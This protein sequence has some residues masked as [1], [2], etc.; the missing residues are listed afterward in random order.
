[1]SD[2]GQVIIMGL[3]YLIKDAL[4]LDYERK[5]ESDIQIKVVGI[6][7]GGCNSI[8]RL[9]NQGINAE[10]IAI[11]TDKTH[12]S[13]VNAHKKVLLGEKIT[14]GHGT[15]G[16]PEIGE[17]VAQL[18]VKDIYNIL[19]GADIIFTLAGLGGGTGSG[20]GPVIN[21]IAKET[22]ALVVSIVTMPFKAEGKKRWNIAEVSLEKF[23][24]NANTLIVLDNNRL[25]ELAPKLPILKAFAIMDYL[26]GDVIKNLAETVTLPSLMNVDF[27]DLVAIM[28][29]GGTSTIL[30]GEGNYYTPQDAVLDTLNNPL[31]DIDYRGANGALIHITGGSEMTLQT[32]YRIAE[33]ITSGIKD[34]AEVKIGARIDSSYTKKLKITTILTGVHTPYMPRRNTGFVETPNELQELIS[35]VS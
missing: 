10:L 17:Q 7:G 35:I 31:M 25:L 2:K 30:Y 28:R 18:A 26:I 3:E 8:T 34:N 19:D 21:E 24:E 33:G 16:S 14:H 27:S 11:N 22:G 12:F 1:M 13:I 9:S 32:V 5:V 15:G 6:G 29:N 4:S 20:A 23:R